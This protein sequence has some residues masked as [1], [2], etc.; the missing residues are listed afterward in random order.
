[1]DYS[2]YVEAA[3]PQSAPTLDLEQ[4]ADFSDRLFEA[5]G[6][7]GAVV[8]GSVTREQPRGWSA[9]V[10]IASAR[11]IGAALT[12]GERLVLDAAQAAGLPAWPIVKLE[13]VEW[14]RLGA[15]LKRPPGPELVGIAELADLAGVSRQ[16]AS[17]LA[18]RAGFPDPLATLAAGPVWNLYAVQRFLEGW[19]RQV[20]RPAKQRIGHV[21][22]EFLRVWGAW[23]QHMLQ[24]DLDP[25]L[26]DGYRSV[27]WDWAAFCEQEGQAFEHAT[28]A[29]L[30]RYLVRS[31][32]RAG[33]SWPPDPFVPI[34]LFYAEAKV[35]GLIHHNP[36]EGV[37][38]KRVDTPK[39]VGPPDALHF[40]PIQIRVAD[41]PTVREPDSP[42]AGKRRR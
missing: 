20:G 18:R 41:D 35:L 11:T 27:L 5:D 30:G 10:R 34:V 3:G 24:E 19:P 1:M 42:S 32:H 17:V 36:L 40:V 4:L 7:V 23:R 13:A 14:E 37:T 22:E 26:L 29:L 38:P 31:Q 16:R 2:V 12:S 9:R 6:G 33:R 8:S 21:S 25:E 39:R 28:P 15:E